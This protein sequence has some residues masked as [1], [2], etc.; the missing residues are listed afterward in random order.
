MT[1]FNTPSLKESIERESVHFTKKDLNTAIIT[2]SK[3]A[4][5]DYFKWLAWPMGVVGNKGDS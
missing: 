1:V 2:C 5:S 4:H 3:G